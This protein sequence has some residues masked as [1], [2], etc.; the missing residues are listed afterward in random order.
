[1]NSTKVTVEEKDPKSGKKSKVRK[2]FKP[3][4]PKSA[5]LLRVQEEPL[6]EEIFGIP[7]RRKI[8]LDEAFVE[9]DTE[10]EYGKLCSN[11]K[12]VSFSILI[13][14]YAKEASSL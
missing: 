11:D 13:T 8:T 6:A 10:R 4:H 12:G 3:S 9:Y 1:M 7:Y 5:M 14:D 2:N